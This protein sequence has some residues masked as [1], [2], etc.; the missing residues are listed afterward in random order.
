[1]KNE[2]TLVPPS[3]KELE[4]SMLW[5]IISKPNL[6]NKAK[7]LRVTAE[8]FYATNHAA[9]F[10]VICDLSKKGEPVDFQTVRASLKARNE[11]Y[12]KALGFA[13]SEFTGIS[14]VRFEGQCKRLKRLENTRRMI[15]GMRD[16]LLRLHTSQDYE[17]EMATIEG[18]FAHIQTQNSSLK[19]RDIHEVKDDFLSLM[20][21][22]M[23]ASENDE[24]IGIP[25]KLYD[26][27]KMMNGW[28]P[29]RLY[30]LAARPAMGKTEV[31]VRAM[32]EAARA[33]YKTGFISAEMTDVGI[34][35]RAMSQYTQFQKNE[36]ERGTQFLQNQFETVKRKA[37]EIADTG[38]MIDES[39]PSNHNELV[40]RCAHM[41]KLGC[42]FI[43]ID[44]LGLIGSDNKNESKALGEITRALKVRVCKEFGIPV[45]LL[46]QLSRAVEIRGGDKRPILS[47]LRGSGEI[48]QDAD[49]AIFLYRPEYYGFET[50]EEGNSTKGY[51]EFI[52]AKNRHGATGVV[53]AFYNPAIG[54]IGTWGFQ[55]QPKN[56]MA[57]PVGTLS[58]GA[59]W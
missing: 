12:A 3:E 43:V 9:T 48:E 17:R 38:L 56:D 32:L 34:F 23:K 27:D 47:D 10:S 4:K 53:K 16:S 7:E 24:P 54:T 22:R 35:Q 14:D 28:Q 18:I 30:I 11:D 58:G 59:G 26:F 39:C 1:M 57:I 49:A 21:A 6:L 37:N 19:M 45:L 55:D 15:N 29:N 40:M 20:E 2:L 41:V 50:D 51:L 31:A 46:H 44:Y 36:F 33:G 25:Y 13:F 42:E 5:G 52:I 8:S